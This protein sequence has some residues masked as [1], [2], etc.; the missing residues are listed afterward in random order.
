MNIKKI[1]LFTEGERVGTFNTLVALD[2][3]LNSKSWDIKSLRI[4]VKA[5][6]KDIDTFM[7][8][9]DTCTLNYTKWNKKKQPTEGY[10]TLK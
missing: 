6:L 5:S 1:N 10:I 9:K 8:G 4:F 3:M 7:Q 2:N